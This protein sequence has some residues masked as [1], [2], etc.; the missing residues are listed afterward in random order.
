M[1]LQKLRNILPL[2]TEILPDVYSAGHLRCIAQQKR[3]F[4][5][6]SQYAIG[7]LS[8]KQHRKAN[9]SILNIKKFSD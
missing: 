4:L 7:Q 6:I 9:E 8:S 1:N 2:D 5:S 3:N